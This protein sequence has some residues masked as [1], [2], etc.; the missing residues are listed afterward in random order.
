MKVETVK[1]G[2]IGEPKNL[3]FWKRLTIRV[4]LFRRRLKRDWPV[5]AQNRLALVGVA[6]IVIFGIMAI[7][8]PI[9][10]K[11]VWPNRVYNP[12]TGYDLQIMHPSLPSSSHLLGTDSLGRDVLSMLLAATTP[13]F[14]LGLTAAI[15]TA[16]TGAVVGAV[17][18]YFGGKIDIFLTYITDALMLLPAPLFMI[19]AG[20]TFRDSSS[21]QLGAIYGLIA[22]LGS[23]AIVLRAHALTVMVKP[24]IEASRISGAQSGYII[25]R[26]LIPHLI[27]LA[28]MNMMLAV[29]GAVV[30][31][32]FI[33]FF[34]ITRLYLNWGTMIY[35]SQVYSRIFGLTVPW[36]ELLPP[37][38]ALSL[39]AAAFYLI[40]RG[41]HEVADPNLQ[42]L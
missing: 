31:D 36:H 3:S 12:V 18:A 39:F 22:G 14:I 1:T 7:A 40:A 15:V 2:H 34:G 13:T 28:T 27:P 42:E 17:S 19:I 30:A 26:H 11:T 5:F 8:H 6:L 23:A 41:L 21:I 32:G 25:F 16:V 38:M 20:V 9:L 35:S 37:A 24:F 4:V 33:S 10:M 29:T